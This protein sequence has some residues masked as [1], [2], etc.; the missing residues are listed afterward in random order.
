MKL[1]RR[2]WLSVC[3][4]LVVLLSIAGVFYLLFLYK[5]QP[6]C[7]ASPHTI[8][9]LRHMLHTFDDVA[10]E[11]KVPYWIDFGTLL[12]AVKFKD[13]LPWDRDL[14]ISVFEEDLRTLQ[15]N[16]HRFLARGID[17][18]PIRAVFFVSGT[19][20]PQGDLNVWTR[21]S[22]RVVITRKHLTSRSFLHEFIYQKY[23]D[24]DVRFLQPLSTIEVAGRN[25]SCPNNPDEFLRT[26]RY[27]HTH[28]FNVPYNPACWFK[29]PKIS[30]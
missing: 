17:L 1:S 29:M 28:S 27:P 6:E 14:D 12:G 11:L 15:A 23:Y 10:R 3:I 22:S 30:S 8:Q 13:I 7:L 19:D 21:Q 26:I 18:R 9:S 16:R 25:V 2:V 20:D 24:F 5:D 4:L